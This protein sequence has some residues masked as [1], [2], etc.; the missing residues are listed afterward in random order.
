MKVVLVAPVARRFFNEAGKINNTLAGYDSAVRQ[1]AN[2]LKIP[3][4][5]LTGLTTTFY[6]TL[7]PD[8]SA[9][10][11][12]AKGTDKTHHNAY[13]AFFIANMV[14]QVLIDPANGLDVK[15][16]NDFVPLDPAR[17]PDPLKFELTP[18]DWP[19]MRERAVGVSGS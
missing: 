16:A 13:G 8:K 19:I 7:G 17:P 1:V 11:F 12:G 18:S 3:F 15:P 14:A 4:V 6:E 5:D 2:D 10:A 9:L